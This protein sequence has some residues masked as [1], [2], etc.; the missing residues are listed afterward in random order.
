MASAVL[1]RESTI[2]G[3]GVFAARSFSAGELV[4]AIDD[5]HVVDDEHPVPPGE[6]HHCDYL[7]AGK[8][9]WMQ[10]PERY[11]NHSCEPNVFVRTCDGVRQVLAIREIAAGEE[12]AYDYC[13]NGYGDTV[14]TC[15]C[16][17]ARCRH[18]IHSDFFHLPMELQTRY[19]PLLD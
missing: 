1:V 11:I 15:S 4:L 5:S 2:N 19:L 13:V 7:A 10:A 18:T 3:I 17:A 14:W 6:E 12:I 8:T 9:V 16:G